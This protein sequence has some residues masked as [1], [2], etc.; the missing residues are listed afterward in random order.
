MICLPVD[1]VADCNTLTTLVAGVETTE[2]VGA[3]CT[4]V[5]AFKIVAVLRIP[6]VF[7]EV[8]IVAFVETVVAERS[9]GGL[10]LNAVMVIPPLG[11]EANDEGNIVVLLSFVDVI[12]SMTK[13]LPLDT[14]EV[15]V[16]FPLDEGITCN[17]D[18]IVVTTLSVLGVV[19]MAGLFEDWGMKPLRLA[20]ISA[21]FLR[22]TWVGLAVPLICPVTV[23]QRACFKTLSEA[24]IF[25]GAPWWPR[26]GLGF[27]KSSV[28]AFEVFVIL[29]VVFEPTWH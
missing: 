11:V 18:P 10:D 19:I 28:C 13:L 23:P 20:K 1:P 14:A 7:V 2:G 24:A 15:G 21:T 17:E 9:G 5:L 12:G 25:T 29:V 27:V 22:S 8:I 3:F 16:D 26:V 4:D 6:V